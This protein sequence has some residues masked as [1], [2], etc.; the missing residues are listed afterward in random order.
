MEPMNHIKPC[1]IQFLVKRLKDRNNIISQV[2][3]SAPP[4]NLQQPNREWQKGDPLS[5]C[6]SSRA[7][8]EDKEIVLQGQWRRKRSRPSSGTG[9]NQRPEACSLNRG[10][11]WTVPWVCTVHVG[12]HSAGGPKIFVWCMR[13]LIGSLVLMAEWEFLCG[14]WWWTC[15]FYLIFRS[16]LRIFI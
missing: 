7:K 11:N 3:F 9:R 13:T 2:I 4:S 12:Q 15:D 1:L 8:A 14:F 5:F 10:C 6:F 16:R